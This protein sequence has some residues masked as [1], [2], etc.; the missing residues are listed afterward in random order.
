[1]LSIE[2]TKGTRTFCYLDDANAISDHTG[3]S[4][5]L[6]IREIMLENTMKDGDVDG[7]S[8]VQPVCEYGITL[9]DASRGVI[10]VG[11]FADD[12]LRNRMNTL[13]TSFQPSEVSR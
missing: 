3:S 2:A 1:M 13:L 8:E 12:I 4:P 7:D 9:V 11:Q 6:A 10:T 5:L